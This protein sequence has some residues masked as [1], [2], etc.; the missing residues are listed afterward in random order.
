MGSFGT[1]SAQ[2]LYPTRDTVG[3]YADNTPLTPLAVGVGGTFSTT[4][5]TPNTAFSA[6]V[7][8]QLKV[9]MNVITQESGSFY[10]GIL[11]SWAANGSSITVSGWFQQG[12]TSAGQTPPNSDT[13][14]VNCNT[15]FWGINVNAIYPASGSVATQSTIIEAGLQDNS[16]TA[17]TNTS[18][19]YDAVNLTTSAGRDAFIARNA[20]D[21]GFQ[22]NNTGTA[23]FYVPASASIS[24]GF[25]SSQ[26][27]GTAFQVNG[28]PGAGFSSSQTTGSVFN[29]GGALSSGN[30]FHSA[31]FNVNYL[32]Q[33]DIGSTTSPSSSPVALHSSGHAGADASLSVSGGTGATDGTLTIGAGTLNLSVGNGGTAAKYVCVDSSNNVVIQSGAC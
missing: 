13:V 5:F 15:K 6:G 16:A 11:T 19:G 4:T 27:S 17:L 10:S 9:N 7:V 12:N 20:W 2:A 25:L 32:G 3:I 31:Q 28:N 18:W 24:A 23:G 8:S 26:N 14:C 1:P 29:S 21:Y 22:A 30:Y 33:V